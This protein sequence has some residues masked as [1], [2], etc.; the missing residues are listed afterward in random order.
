MKSESKAEDL[1]GSTLKMTLTKNE[2]SG[3]WDFK[4]KNQ[5]EALYR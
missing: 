5:R 1:F 2:N 3:L 4:E